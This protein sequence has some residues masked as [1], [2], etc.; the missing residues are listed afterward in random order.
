MTV[1]CNIVHAALGSITSVDIAALQLQYP[2]GFKI[3]YNGAGT[4][5]SEQAENRITSVDE[6]SCRGYSAGPGIEYIGPDADPH[7]VA[8]TMVYTAQLDTDTDPDSCA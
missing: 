8:A 4:E 3:S 5:S 6:H 7:F 1:Y 2:K